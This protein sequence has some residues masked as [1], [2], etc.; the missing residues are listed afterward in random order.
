M[1][2]PA[3]IRRVHG[4]RAGGECARECTSM[5]EA[6]QA[7]VSK[8][9]RATARTRAVHVRAR[10]RTERLPR[11]KH[12]LVSRRKSESGAEREREGWM[13]GKRE[14]VKE[15]A[16]RWEEGQRSESA[17]PRSMLNRVSL[18]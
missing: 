7:G 16:G 5:H 17:I 4:E 3:C 1:C 15:G 14:R 8:R 6:G 13:L 9:V 18:R 10:T 11:S 12:A 2:A